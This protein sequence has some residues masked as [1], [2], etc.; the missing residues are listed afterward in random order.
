[1][2]TGSS[3]CELREG[4]LK[5]LPP[6]PVVAR[7]VSWTEKSW[8]TKL[9]VEVMLELQHV[10]RVMGHSCD[11]ISDAT[12]RQPEVTYETSTGDEAYDAYEVSW[13]HSPWPRKRGVL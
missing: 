10:M 5:C 11:S 3:D 8:S 7:G 1:M 2:D 4:P 6:L 12:G 9:R 13:G